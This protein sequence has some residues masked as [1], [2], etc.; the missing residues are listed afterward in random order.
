[1]IRFALPLA[2]ALTLGACS[3]LV[4]STM[5][6]LPDPPAP[7]AGSARLDGAT[8]AVSRIS[9]P[10]Y[11]ER[12][13]VA[14][15]TSA[16]AAV[17]STDHIWADPLSRAASQALARALADRGAALALAEPWPLEFYP[18]LRVDVIADQFIGALNGDVRFSG[19]FRIAEARGSLLLGQ[20]FDLVTPTGG[21][22]YDALAQAHARLV[23]LLADEIAASLVGF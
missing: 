9:L 6:L 2:A 22:G 13:E 4:P 3:G 20:R 11:A 14:T 23:G 21:T 16:S 18:D 17:Q 19:E 8:V 10:D 1:M 15:L 7:G 12:P 5:H